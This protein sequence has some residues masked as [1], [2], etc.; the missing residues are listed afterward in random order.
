[1]DFIEVTCSRRTGSPRRWS[2][3]QPQP[4]Q[5]LRPPE[6]YSTGRTGRHPAA[7]PD[8]AAVVCR[9]HSGRGGSAAPLRGPR[10]AEGSRRAQKKARAAHGFGVGV[11][12][13]WPACPRLSALS[14][15]AMSKATGALLKTGASN[16]ITCRRAGSLVRGAGAPTE[17]ASRRTGGSSRTIGDTRR[18]PGFRPRPRR[19]APG[20]DTAK[21]PAD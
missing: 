12:A 17:N 1:M 19:P 7:V 16:A 5:Y 15:A 4:R 11:G 10:P 18:W 21:A 2:V 8:R 13:E 9:D 20:T 6:A 14:S 3:S